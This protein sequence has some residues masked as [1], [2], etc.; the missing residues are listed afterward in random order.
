MPC[1]PKSLLPLSPTRQ[2]CI[3]IDFCSS[4]H[5]YIP[6]VIIHCTIALEREHLDREGIYRISGTVSAVTKL[7]NDFLFSRVIPDLTNV[8]T[9][10]ITGCIKKFLKELNIS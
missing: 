10:N 2:N 1:I 6:S 4:S 5:P 9:E 3:L 7:L 8:P